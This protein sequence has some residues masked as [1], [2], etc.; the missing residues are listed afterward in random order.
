MAITGDYNLYQQ[1][2]YNFGAL[3]NRQDAQRLAQ[4]HYQTNAWQSQGAPNTTPQIIGFSTVD[5]MKLAEQFAQSE[6]SLV[7]NSFGVN[8]AQESQDYVPTGTGE[9]SPVLE[10]RE[11]EIEDCPWREYYA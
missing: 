4:G 2:P 5:D 8:Q 10:G 1:N 6:V 7:A 11:D 9:L 3:T